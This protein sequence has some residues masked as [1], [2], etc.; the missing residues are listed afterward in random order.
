M[1]GEGQTA[2]IFVD[3]AEHQLDLSD[4]RGRGIRPGA[5]RAL[6]RSAGFAELDDSGV[7]KKRI[8]R[9]NEAMT[10]LEALVP[11]ALKVTG[12]GGEPVVAQV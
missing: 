2:E 7:I 1:L 6:D 8:T 4:Q 12:A 9:A 10:S 11:L 3:V 5:N